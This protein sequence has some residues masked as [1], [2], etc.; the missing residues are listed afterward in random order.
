MLYNENKVLTGSIYL[1]YELWSQNFFKISPVAR[2][3][4]LRQQRGRQMAERRVMEQRHEAELLLL[5]NNQSK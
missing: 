5:E 4:G 2:T 1:F 3:G